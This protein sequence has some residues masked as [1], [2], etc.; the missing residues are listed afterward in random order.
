MIDGAA[1]LLPEFEPEP[2]PLPE[3][4]EPDVLPDPEPVPLLPE[5]EPE[6]LPDPDPLP[7]PE[8]KVNWS[9]LSVAD[10]P[11]IETT[12]MSTVPVTPIG[13]T[14]EIVFAPVTVNVVA[15]LPK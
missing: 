7:D 14:A 12:V 10:V 11:A 6:P 15:T 8:V 13:A 5:V 4:P 2:L 9:R 1:E 3:D